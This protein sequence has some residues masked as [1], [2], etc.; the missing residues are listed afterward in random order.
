MF[1]PVP[2]VVPAVTIVDGIASDHIAL[3]DYPFLESSRNPA[4]ILDGTATLGKRQASCCWP[5]V[6][7]LLYISLCCC[8][9]TTYYEGHAVRVRHAPRSQRQ[10][11]LQTGASALMLCMQSLIG[12]AARVQMNIVERHA[13]Q[14]GDKLIGIISEVTVM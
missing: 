7:F 2:A 8:A 4:A 3:P 6:C 14:R 9:A 11:R 13:F 1:A 12:S 5:F 10:R